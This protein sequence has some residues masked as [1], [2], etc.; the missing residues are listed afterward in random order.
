MGNKQD[1]VTGPETAVS[2]ED[3][4]NR[5]APDDGTQL[6]FLHAD[7]AFAT[8]G[9]RWDPRQYRDP[10]TALVVSDQ[11]PYA[12]KTVRYADDNES[13]ILERRNFTGSAIRQF[14][15][16]LAY[17]SA[18]ADESSDSVPAGP[19]RQARPNR[20]AGPAADA[21]TNPVP[22]SAIREALANAIVHRDYAFTGPTI[23]N[24]YPSRIEIISLGGLVGG[25]QTNDL[26]NGISQPRNIELATVFERLGIVENYGSGIRAIMRAYGDSHAGPQLRVSPSSVAVILPGLRSESPNGDDSRDANQADAAEPSGHP[27]GATAPGSDGTAAKRYRF[28]VGYVTYVELPDGNSYEQI[29]LTTMLPTGA[30]SSPNSTGMRRVPAAAAAP[31]PV[32]MDSSHLEPLILSF[33][34]AKGVPLRRIEIEQP[35]HLTRAQATHTLRNLVDDGSVRRIGNSRTTRYVAAAAVPDGGERDARP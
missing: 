24:I 31:R 13:K 30:S 19:S 32:R 18:C 1:D 35:L 9:A 29:T 25:L 6:T 16:A 5:Q 34:L 7:A 23:V 11:N 33:M 10:L 28:P 21:S 15:Q 8:A 17:L 22:T 3:H 26:L 27:R 12:V 2:H 14:D 20:Q 4:D